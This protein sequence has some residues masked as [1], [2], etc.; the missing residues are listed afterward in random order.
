MGEFGR[1]CEAYDVLSEGEGGLQ[2]VWISPAHVPAPAKAG[3]AG[4]STGGCAASIRWHGCCRTWQR[5]VQVRDMAKSVLTHLAAPCAVQPSEKASLTCMGRQGLKKASQTGME[6]RCVPTCIL[7]PHHGM[8]WSQLLMAM[9]AG[10]KGGIYTFDPESTPNQV[11]ARFFGTANPFEALDGACSCSM[12]ITTACTHT[13]STSEN[14]QRAHS[15]LFACARVHAAIAAQFEAMTTKEQL[16]TG[17]N[18]LV[19][20]SRHVKPAE[21]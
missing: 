9:T 8:C 12:H 19:S 6:V 20:G 21:R 1:V 18:K 11:F 5:R 7:V 3:C 4:G 2:G 10:L 13:S 14:V 17:K 16:K 15:M